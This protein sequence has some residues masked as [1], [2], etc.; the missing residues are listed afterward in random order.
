MN[1]IEY[2]PLARVTMKELPHREHLIHMA[3]GIVG[4]FGEL[5]DAVK[6]VAIYGKPADIVNYTEEIG[7]V[8]WYYAGLHRELSVDP[9]YS[10]EA[11]HEGMTC[12]W[13]TT[14]PDISNPIELG[15]SMVMLNNVAA[16]QC[17]ALVGL[18]KFENEM[19]VVVLGLTI[20]T[21][22]RSLG[23]NPEDAME[24]NIAKLKARY[25]DKFSAHAALHR[26]LAG[27]RKV[28]EDGQHDC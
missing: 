7:D 5:I 16:D 24:R 15:A 11:L 27:E 18:E 13:H 9:V 10:Q 6:K 17:A 8:L 21:V 25:G 28:L 22:A 23:V 26:D 2:V 20:A 4:E 3:L 1:F 14:A 19:G 12:E